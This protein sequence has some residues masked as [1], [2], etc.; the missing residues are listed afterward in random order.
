M[1]PAAKIKPYMTKYQ[2][3]EWLREAPD[4]AAFQRRQAIWLTSVEQLH[5]YRV[6]GMLG[7]STQVV[8]LW[9]GQYNKLGQ[10]GLERTGRGGRHW[11]FLS[12]AQE[13]QVIQE[14]LV[15]VDIDADN[16]SFGKKTQNILE[17]KLGRKVSLAYA[18]RL[19]KRNNWSW[20]LETR[21]R[22]MARDERRRVLPGGMDNFQKFSRP[23]RW[24]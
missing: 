10:R 5:A 17:Q 23:W 7:V 15:M 24:R 20:L 1:R 9:I 18:Y 14:L 4:K 8:W 21:L 11:S 6:A 12:Y 16:R 3:Q 2:M 19:L 22:E 13:R